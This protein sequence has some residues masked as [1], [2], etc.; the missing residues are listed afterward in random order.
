MAQGPV[1]PV[2]LEGVS[3]AARAD[4]KLGQGLQ[5]L[6]YRVKECEFE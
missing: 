3:R 4:K 5:G 1:E 2:G 6:V